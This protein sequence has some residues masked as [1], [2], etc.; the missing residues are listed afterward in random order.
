M[1]IIERFEE[2]DKERDKVSEQKK[3]EKEVQTEKAEDFRKASMETFGESRKRKDAEG[4][5]STSKR[6]RATG[7]DTIQFLREK[8]KQ[9]FEFRK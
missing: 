1:N 9:D 8:S 6:Q 7:S 3:K 5:E 4:S 2:A